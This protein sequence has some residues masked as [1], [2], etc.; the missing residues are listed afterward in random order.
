MY[1]SING[2]ETYY[3]I[4][5]EGLAVVMLHGWGSDHNILK[6]CME[7]LFEHKSGFK[8]IYIDL[9]GMGNT[10]VNSSIQ[11]SDD[12]KKHIELLLNQIIG[13]ENFVII[14]KSYGAYLSRGIIKDNSAKIVG[15]LQICP[16]AFVATQLEH[17]PE[18]VV[19]EKEPDIEQI[20]PKEDWE[21][22]DLFHVRQTKEV[23]QK[24]KQFILPGTKKADYNFLN[25]V[26]DKNRE[27][28]SSVDNDN[29]YEFPTLFLCGRQDWCVGYSDLFTLIEQYKYASY[30]IINKAGHNL[31]Y[32]QPEIFNAAVSNWLSEVLLFANC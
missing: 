30:M 16:L 27:F 25:N 8:R 12:M 32:E 7:P 5:G 28:Q 4:I 31:E 3:E 22:F 6:G 15:C 26:L 20:V 29:N 13:N 24:Y 2:I 18:R 14:G 17:A 21:Y 23:W 9:P 1:I 10:K 11:T 19:L